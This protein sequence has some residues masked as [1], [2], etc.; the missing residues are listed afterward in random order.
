MTE[1]EPAEVDG[2]RQRAGRRRNFQNV[3]QSK[4]CFAHVTYVEISRQVLEL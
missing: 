1:D 2:G 3:S 4:R